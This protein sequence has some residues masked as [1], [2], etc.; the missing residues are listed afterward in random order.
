MLGIISAMATESDLIAQA[1]TD[2]EET[3]VSCLKM[4]KGRLSG[5][6]AV[7]ITGAF[8]KVSAAIAAQMLVDRFNVDKIINIGVAGGLHRDMRQCDFVVADN[9]VQHDVDTTAI[10]DPI[11]MISGLYTDYFRADEQIS[12]TLIEAVRKNTGKEPFTGTFATGDQFVASKE[13][14]DFI[15]DTFGAIACEMEGGAIAQTCMM[16]GVPFAALR[17]ISDNADGEAGM[18]Y[19]EFRDKTAALCA[20]IVIDTAGEL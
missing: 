19:D 8:G 12:K 3:A 9:F 11:A 14:S 6:E 1:M 16:L 2:T 20:R 5:R 7:I 4:I 10:G 17:C 18:S 13:R 15:R